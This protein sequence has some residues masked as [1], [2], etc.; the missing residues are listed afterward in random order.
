[1]EAM[2]ITLISTVMNESENIRL[3]LD[4]ILN[5]SK[6]LNEVIIIDGNSNDP[7][8][9][10]LKEYIVKFKKQNIKYLTKIIPGNRAV[11]RN[12]AIELSSCDLIVCSDAGCI[13]DKDWVKNITIPIKNKKADVVAGYYKGI[14][15]SI[16]QKCLIPYVLVMPD[17][18]DPYKFLPATRSMAFTKKIW[19]KA[20]GFPEKY[21][22]NEDFVFAH[23]LKVIGARIIF[24]KEALVY[25]IPV[26]NLVHA[27]NMFFR[28]A[29]GDI[30]AKILRPKVI[31]IN[32]RYILGIL[33]L[34]LAIIN[35]DIIL[36][37]LFSVLL[38]LY[39]VWAIMKNY[40][41]VNNYKAI[42]I[43]PILQFVSDIAVIGG[44]LTGL[45]NLWGIKKTQ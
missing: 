35:K 17:R 21:S 10:I 22:D 23:K 26:R 15:N 28:F 45:I 40:K 36:L 41:Y 44:T 9:K 6:K 4:S 39:I 13:L 14:T 8:S 33:L 5:Q 18:V 43:L 29:K 42:V 25:W 32:V 19:K 27:Y 2:K 20:Q 12:K 24:V 30:E 3:F 31:L 7:T 37:M 11:G 16:F 38:V 34:L 1:M